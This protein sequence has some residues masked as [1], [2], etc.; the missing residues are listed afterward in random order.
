MAAEAKIQAKICRFLEKE[1]FIVT[2]IIVANRAGTHDIVACDP[3][4]R[5]WSIEVKAP[6][7]KESKLQA[8]KRK[9][10]KQNKAI[11]FTCYSFEEFTANYLSAV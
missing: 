4:G 10:L 3:A 6:N 5:Y 1:G 9:K 2:K 11:V 8:H 7:G